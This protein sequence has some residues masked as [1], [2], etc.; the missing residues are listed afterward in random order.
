MSNDCSGLPI[1]AAEKSFMVRRFQLSISSLPFVSSGGQLSH[2]GDKGQFRRYR[3]CEQMARL[4][5]QSWEGVWSLRLVIG[6]PESFLLTG[7]NGTKLTFF[8][9]SFFFFFFPSEAVSQ[10]WHY[11]G[12]GSFFLW[13]GAFLCIGGRVSAS[14]SSFHRMPGAPLVVTARI[15]SRLCQMFPGRETNFALGFGYWSEGTLLN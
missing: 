15:V 8:F 1:L 12:L 7:H 10:P 2:A 6:L 13:R 4:W 14:S 11:S 9:F 5:L 3:N